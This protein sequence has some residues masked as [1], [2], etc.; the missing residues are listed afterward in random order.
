MGL[1]NL[2]KCGHSFPE[3]DFTPANISISQVKYKALNRW[4]LAQPCVGLYPSCYPTVVWAKQLSA[5]SCLVAPLPHNRRAGFHST[6]QPLPI[7]RRGGLDMDLVRN[8]EGECD[9]NRCNYTYIFKQPWYGTVK[10]D[11]LSTCISVPHVKNNEFPY[12]FPESQMQIQYQNRCVHSGL[13]HHQE[14]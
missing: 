11:E 5:S 13:F 10:W 2:S 4:V 14:T 3:P 6:A 9:I 7:S 1:S 8:L 12:F